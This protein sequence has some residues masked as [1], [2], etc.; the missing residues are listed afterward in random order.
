VLKPKSPTM[1]H[2]P[3]NSQA[4]YYC[5][6][7]A[8]PF[9]DGRH[10]VERPT[11]NMTHPYTE[12]VH[13]RHTR[14]C[15]SRTRSRPRSCRAC[16]AAKTKCNFETP[17]SRCTKRN[18][19]CIYTDVVH[20]P[21][22]TPDSSTSTSATPTSI[23]SE[24]VLSYTSNLEISDLLPPHV[25]QVS[26][27]L[28]PILHTPDFSLDDFMTF[29]TLSPFENTSYVQ[30]L[31]QHHHEAP[32]WCTWS[33]GEV[34]LTVLYETSL[35]SAD[36]MIPW[37]NERPHAQH[38]A[39]LM[40]QSLRSLPTMM[41]RTETFPWSIHRYSY[42]TA[43]G[44]LPEAL[45]TCMSVAQLFTMRTPETKGFLW[46]TM[47]NEYRQFDAY[48]AN[49]SVYELK[50]AMQA[51]MIY[52]IMCI[53]DQSP[54]SEKIIVELL[55]VLHNIYM[56]AKATRGGNYPPA[57]LG[58]H[59]STTWAEWVLAESLIRGA[60]IWFLI[61]LVICIKTGTVC[62]PSQ[63]YRGLLLPCSKSLWEASS[64]TAWLQQYESTRLQRANGLVTLGDLID[65]QKNSFIPYEA[66]RLDEWNASADGLGMLLNMVGTMV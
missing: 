60:L 40:I 66:R 47:R 6:K 51:C 32:A 58:S 17:C 33:R 42:N 30:D 31:E 4:I 49:M 63:S 12:T 27:E 57:A 45:S 54:E 65:A 13:T 61:G 52:L 24:D 43:E 1:D 36:F 34:S 25:D 37:L 3:P 28:L 8:K 48:K 15:G 38:N 55:A 59:M 23:A 50:Y 10:T 41:L 26:K 35:A 18:I 14:Y 62:D 21:R 64:E 46:S 9:L 2:A 7:C 5:P 19:K 53:V 16:N 39:N 56:L 44:K 20:R 29:E 11:C 22:A